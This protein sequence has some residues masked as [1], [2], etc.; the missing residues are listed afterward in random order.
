MATL[1]LAVYGEWRGDF[2]GAAS[3]ARSANEVR[4]TD[5]ITAYT[6]R[7]EPLAAVVGDG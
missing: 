6:P 1:N 5:W 2:A 7:M 4:E 3:K